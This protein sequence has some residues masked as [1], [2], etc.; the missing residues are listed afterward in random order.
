M[1]KVFWVVCP[2]CERRYYVNRGL[3]GKDVQLFCPFCKSYFMSS[4]A[5]EIIA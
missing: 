3:L 2:K 1:A 5:K 4:E